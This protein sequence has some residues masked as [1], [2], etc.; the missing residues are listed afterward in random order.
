MGALVQDGFDSQPFFGAGI[1]YQVNH[2]RM[3]GQRTADAMPVRTD[4]QGDKTV[5]LLGRGPRYIGLRG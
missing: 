2:D 5:K 4:S 1:G 3:T